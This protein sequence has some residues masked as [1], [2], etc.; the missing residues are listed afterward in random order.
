M[1]FLIALVAVLTVLCLLNLLLV[2]GVIRRLREHT[3]LLAAQKGGTATV[4]I[5]ERISDFEATTVDG[6]PLSNADLGAETVA[7]FF[8]PSCKPCQAKLPRFVEYAGQL[9]GGRD[10]VLVT[11]AAEDAAEASEFVRKLSPVAR[12]VVEEGNGPVAE[13]FGV[14]MFPTL[15]RVAP[16][17]AGELVVTANRVRLDRALATA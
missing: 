8:S 14:Q 4:S 1:S 12:V 2:F 9:P 5:G 11:V 16:N 3:E 13:A 7:A 10:Q 6:M 15:L 17:D